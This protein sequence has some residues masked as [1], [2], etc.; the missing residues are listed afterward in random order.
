M[1]KGKV[2]VVGVTGSIAAF[3]AASLVSS[4]IN[5]G[6]EVQVI[7]TR[8]ATQFIHPITFET[9]TGNKCLVETFDRNFQFHVAHV[10]L[11]KR[12]DAMVIAPAT[13]NVIGKLANGIADDMLTTTALAYNKTIVL[14]PAMNVNM[15]ENKIVQ[16]NMTKLRMFGFQIIEP[17]V[18]RLACNVV[19]KGKMAEESEILAELE[20]MLYEK[21]DLLGKKILVTAGPTREAIDPVRFI[22]NHS[23]GKMGYALAKNAMQRGANVT[24]IT[25]PVE[26][27]PPPKV[28]VIKITSAAE[29]FETVRQTMGEQDIIIK[30][31]AVADYCSSEAAEHK[32]KKNDN[33]VSLQL[34]PTTDI[35]KYVCEHKNKGQYV[36]GFS[37]E[38]ENLIENSK[39]KLENK[40][41]DMIVANNLN[42]KGAG[43]GG[44]TNIVTILTKDKI[45]PVECMEKEKV[46]EKILD[47]IC[48]EQIKLVQ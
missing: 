36:C 35:L 26:L 9:L 32:I 39:K 40:K 37:M 41:A 30:A 16:D 13:A 48:E 38:T 4:L 18:G 43:F 2:V 11:A 29:M 25:G 31:A 14:A 15:Y 21:K 23:T 44:N 1:L 20:T 6:C 33:V 22:T 5:R 46:A 12:A 47:S 27:D 8:N 17:Q 10:S 19:A 24:L 42:E 45:I 28:K 3:K 7:M 34:N